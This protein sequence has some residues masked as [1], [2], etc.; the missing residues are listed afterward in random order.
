MIASA[1]IVTLLVAVTAL[2]VAAEFAGVAARRSAVKASADAGSSRS[3]AILPYIDSPHAQDQLVAACQIGITA[4]SLLLGAYGQAAIARSIVAPMLMERGSLSSDTALTTAATLTLIVL[5]ALLVLFGEL[6]PKAIA[7]RH[8]EAVIRRLAWPV[9]GSVRVLKPAIALFNGTSTTILKW[10][11]VQAVGHHAHL[12][13]PDEIELLVTESTAAGELDHAER[14]LL[15][16]ALDL[17]EMVARQVMIPRNR[18]DLADVATPVPELLAHLAASPHSRVAVY[19][20]NPD[21]IIGAIHLKEVHRLFVANESSLAGSLEPVPLVPETFPVTELWRLLLD[22]PATMAVVMDE[23]GGTAGIVTRDRLVGEVIGEVQDEFDPRPE[24]VTRPAKGPPLVRGDLSVEDVND[25]LGVDLPVD[26]PDSIGGLVFE[27]LGRI[28][29]A[30]DEVEI[31]GV[32][33]RVGSM[34][35]NSIARISVE[36]QRSVDG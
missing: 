11:G 36:G 23:F 1:M 20:G 2:Y 13:D 17:G 10:A 27:T 15:A 19:Q 8:P 34:S 4:A 7:L 12:H 6:V 32:R 28:P 18:L 16:N 26:G 14:R 33:L 22:R 5:T 3:A 30:G 24:A 35:G 31:E 21:N 9:I 25:L 29:V